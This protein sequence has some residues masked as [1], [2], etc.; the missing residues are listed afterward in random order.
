MNLLEAFKAGKLEEAWGTG[1]AAV[2]SAPIGES[3]STGPCK[4]VNNVRNRRSYSYALVILLQVF[5]GGKN[6]RPSSLGQLR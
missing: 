1:T 5:N 2:I 3:L 6:K 4:P